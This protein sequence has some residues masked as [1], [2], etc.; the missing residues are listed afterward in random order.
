MGKPQDATEIKRYRKIIL[1]QTGQES[2]AAEER[3][4]V[5]KTVNCI[6]FC[7]GQELTRKDVQAL[8]DGKTVTVIVE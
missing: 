1:T 3:Y 5:K 6:E 2:D 8:L 7:I 4:R